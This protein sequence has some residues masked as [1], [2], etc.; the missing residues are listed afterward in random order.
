MLNRGV[1]AGQ[2]EHAPFNMIGLVKGHSTIFM[3]DLTLCFWA[4]LK[5]SKSWIGESKLGASELVKKTAGIH[6]ELDSLNNC[7]SGHPAWQS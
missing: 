2:F 1:S 5:A 3:E 7:P 6:C 4:D